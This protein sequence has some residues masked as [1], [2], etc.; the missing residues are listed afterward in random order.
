MDDATK[1]KKIIE[2]DFGEVAVGVTKIKSIKIVNNSNNEQ[3]YVVQRDFM[4]NP[5]DQVF[6]AIDYTWSLMPCESYM[7]DI[8]Y[9]P[10][11]PSYKYTDY[12][13][14]IDTYNC[15]YKVIVRGSSAAVNVVSSCTR[16]II[17]SDKNCS[18]TKCI[19]LINH[20]KIPA[21][22]TFDV[23][24]NQ[25]PFKINELSGIIKPLSDK[26]IE[27]SFHSV[28]N[29]IYKY[30]MPCLILHQDPIIFELY[31][32]CDLS[33]H[34]IRNI[35]SI[36]EKIPELDRARSFINYMNDTTTIVKDEP[37]T[38]S[39]SWSFVDF[40]EA[41]AGPNNFAKRAPQTVC[42]TNNSRFDVLVLWEKDK[43][44]IFNIQ[45]QEA[46]V[47]ENK[48][49]I[50]EVRF[51]PTDQCKFYCRELL[52]RIFRIPCCTINSQIS[53]NLLSEIV[54]D[55][56]SIRLMGHSYDHGLNDWIPQYEIPETMT[57]PPCV[58][59][60]PVYSTFIMRNFGQQPLMFHFIPP[61]T[62][63]FS[64]KPMMG[65]I[66]RKQEY[67]VIV[68]EL[69]PEACADPAYVER[70]AIR[71]NGNSK[72]EIYLDLQGFAEQGILVFGDENFV[73]FDPVH[74]GCK[75]TRAVSVRNLSRHLVRFEYFTD[76]P[77]E[78]LISPMMGIVYPNETVFHNWT[79]MPNQLKFYEFDV[80]CHTTTNVG[81]RRC[82]TQIETSASC[83]E[84]SLMAM[85]EELNLGMRIYKE[86]CEID[87]RIFNFSPVKI[88]YQ[89]ICR[90][91]KSLDMMESPEK[92]LKILPSHGNIAPGKAEGIKVVL[93][94]KCVGLYEL[95][96]DY[97]MI[98][99]A[100]DD[101][102]LPLADS[103]SLCRLTCM[104]YLPQLK[105]KDLLYRVDANVGIS[106]I[107]LW[108]SLC[109]DGLNSALKESQPNVE[110]LIY[111][112]VPPIGPDET[113]TVKL[114]L[115]NLSPTDILWNLKKKK[116]CFCNE[117]TAKTRPIVT[118][119]SKSHC[120]NC[121]DDP[122][123]EIYPNQMKLPAGETCILT[124]NI[125]SCPQHP[126]GVYWNL[127]IGNERI[128]TLNINFECSFILPSPY[129]NFKT[130]DIKELPTMCYQTICL[131]NN[132]ENEV[133]YVIKTKA[134]NYLNKRNYAI[135]FTCLNPEGTIQG[136]ERKPVLF[137]FCPNKFGKFET[138]LPIQLG[139]KQS[140]VKL[141]GECTCTLNRNN[142]HE[143]CPQSD[144]FKA[145]DIIA[146]FSSDY[147]SLPPISMH[148]KIN[149]IIM[150]HN[151]H[152]YHVFSYEWKT[153]EI[154]KVIK[155]KIEP[156]SGLIQPQSILT[157]VIQVWAYSYECHLEVDV[158]CHF[159]DVTEKNL[160]KRK[161]REQ[162]CL[163]KGMDGK[164]MINEKGLSYPRMPVFDPIKKP[165]TFW[166][167]LTLKIDIHNFYD[168][169][170]NVNVEQQLKS[171]P[172]IEETN[173]DCMPNK[174]LPPDIV[175]MSASIIENV[176][177]EI[178][179]NRCFFKLIEEYLM[180]THKLKY[181]N[182]PTYFENR[183]ENYLQP[184]R[185]NWVPSKK[186]TSD[187]LRNMICMITHEEF[188]FDTSHFSHP[189]DIKQISY[190]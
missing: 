136:W 79:F 60:L 141:Q 20:A 14:I 93:N 9:R 98:S 174:K 35:F 54:P 3:T 6:N 89:L 172:A 161:Q 36:V 38:V 96:I 112:K 56:T 110:S 165:S 113:L 105:V 51:D 65:L 67:Q 23:D 17:T 91:L 50:F 74:F 73:T 135:I 46:K 139:D 153:C 92:D 28:A 32:L 44:G 132:S 150:L 186:L 21:M 41:K 33:Q 12:F 171:T 190:T 173:C 90:P 159:V 13:F 106:K 26:I 30:Y 145:S 7:C 49:V 142:E 107:S 8:S 85:P 121:V 116:T 134:L 148:S 39:L 69:F 16:L 34:E 72:N 184:K 75:Q 170:G 115:I 29:G 4:S 97:L 182:L 122:S 1:D 24:V 130:V 52:A 27:I 178:I 164:F 129:L 188:Q 61:K 18:A 64:I 167:A 104:C 163:L 155:V 88:H 66:T 114:L 124:I 183:N 100:S 180:K 166:K 22:F 109:I 94:P 181:S 176:V 19:K 144:V 86:N 71:L 31:G 143:T 125:K 81:N 48:S 63:H 55:F 99:N 59:A 58:P 151:H 57:M 62:T 149:R 175:H 45:P 140:T 70:W 138:M 40:G 15:C 162:E 83:T 82:I 123:I 187:I 126:S 77:K 168:V 102:I 179:N 53:D 152:R 169:N 128:I 42:L 10:I 127:H 157:F 103:K 131:H 147:L 160:A 117:S 5:L 76:L 158:H 87:F 133:S 101:V 108:K 137:G 118:R 119:N 111:M 2:V 25:C 43:S 120:T 156:T 84:G 185:L 146:Y 189:P 80:S 177:W 68:V 11:L 154:A 47:S 78:L 95:T 37:P